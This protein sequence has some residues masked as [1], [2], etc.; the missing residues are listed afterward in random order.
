MFALTP[1]E[2]EVLSLSLKVASVAV[3]GSLPVGVLV[4]F[5]LARGRFPGR[6]FLDVLVHFPII[7]PPIVV[8]YLLLMMFSRQ[9]PLGGWL[10]DQFG[11]SVAFSWQAAAIAAGVMGFPLMVRSIRLSIELIDRRLETAA[12]TLGAPPLRVFATVTLPLAL[13]GVLTGLTLAFARA[14][15][16]FGAT[17]VFAANIPGQTR[18]LPLALYTELQIPGQDFAAVRLM[19]LSL[20][21]AVGALVISELI[22]RQLGKRVVGMAY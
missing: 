6:I 1:A 2:I 21:L 20:A 18:T 19:L 11:I 5:A 16:E 15:G 3:I 9:S 17:I 22:S 4:A 13:P 12:Q 8:G 10:F 14:L 7:A